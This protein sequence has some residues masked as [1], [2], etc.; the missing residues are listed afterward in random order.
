MPSQRHRRWKRLERLVVAHAHVLGAPA[1]GQQ[2]V[3]G[4]D[5]RVVEAGRDRVALGD[6]ARARRRARSEREPCSTETRPPPIEAAC[7][8]APSP[9]ASTP[10]SRTGSSRNAWNAPIAFEPP[11]TQATT[12]SGRRPACA[13]HLR[14]RLAADHRLQL[15][16]ERGVGVRAGG[17]ADQV[18]R[19]LDVRD[20]VADGLVHGLLER[21]RAGGDGHDRRAQQV[22]AR[23]VG[24]LAARVLL[25][26]VDDALEAEARAHRRARDAVLAGAGLGDDALLAEP[27]ARAAPGRRRC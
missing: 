15:A 20:P 12:A 4:P 5:A 26:H 10:I 18:V 6:L 11:P 2:R 17:R 13:E 8:S 21:R 3:L 22:H 25:A 9:P 16:H 24:R 7:R 27:L 23:D 14:A 1:L 19:R